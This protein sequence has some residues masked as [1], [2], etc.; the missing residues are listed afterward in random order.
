[1]SPNPPFA[2]NPFTLNKFIK[3]RNTWFGLA[4]SSEANTSLPF[5]GGR[6]IFFGLENFRV[7]HLTVSFHHFQMYLPKF[8][9]VYRHFPP[10]FEHVSCCW[11]MTFFSFRSAW[12]R[13]TFRSAWPRP[14]FYS[15]INDK[16]QN[17]PNIYC[18]IVTRM[19]LQLPDQYLNQLPPPIVSIHIRGR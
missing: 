3:D 14:K 16:I 18:I 11:L 8:F 12:P 9:G 7:I 13:P 2:L 19:F 4:V 1:M 5:S 17:I 10:N 15:L 6:P